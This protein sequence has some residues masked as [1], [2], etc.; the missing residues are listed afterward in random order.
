MKITPLIAHEPTFLKLT[1]FEWIVAV[2]V[3]V[4]IPLFFQSVLG[5]FGIDT[6]LPFIFCFTGTLGFLVF[7]YLGK[8]KEQD[9]L[10]TLLNNMLV[11]D[12]IEGHFAH[13]IPAR[14]ER[15]FAG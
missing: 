7:L 5:L 15:S 8:G 1:K 9:Y 11:P 13:V 14:K 2:Q 6:Y 12:A 10:T 3:G 4:F